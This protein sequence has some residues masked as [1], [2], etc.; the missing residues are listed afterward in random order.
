MVKK[1]HLS[2]S[3]DINIISIAHAVTPPLPNGLTTECGST[4]GSSLAGTLRHQPLSPP[5]LQCSEGAM[6]VA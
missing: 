2:A 5:Q 4:A 1:V 3:I 6:G